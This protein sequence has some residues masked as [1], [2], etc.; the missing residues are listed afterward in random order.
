MILFFFVHITMYTKQLEI[1]KLYLTLVVLYKINKAV[2]RK[3]WT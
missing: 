1:V 3:G 2:L